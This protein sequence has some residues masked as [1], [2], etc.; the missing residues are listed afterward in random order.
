M[1]IHRGAQ[2]AEEPFCVQKLLFSKSLHK[3]AGRDRPV[4]ST[5]LGNFDTCGQ[6]SVE[7]AYPGVPKQSQTDF[8]IP[9]LELHF[10]EIKAV[11]GSNPSL[12]NFTFL[13]FFSFPRPACLLT[14]T[15]LTFA[16]FLLTFCLHLLSFL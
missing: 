1:K 2:W 11:V 14:L 6:E 10:L 15:C 8:K 16:Y 9:N 7:T 3:M 12:S 5:V 13:Y 4:C